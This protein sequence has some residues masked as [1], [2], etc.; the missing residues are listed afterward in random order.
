MNKRSGMLLTTLILFLSVAAI[1]VSLVYGYFFKEIEVDEHDRV[2]GEVLVST[3]IYFQNG[4]TKTPAIL[5]ST[6]NNEVKPNTYFVNISDLTNLYHINKLRVDFTVNSNIETY[7]R[8]KIV[9]SLVIINEKA[10]GEIEEITITRT[11]SIPYVID[12][13]NW[14]YDDLEWFYFKDIVTNE[15]SLINFIQAG[16]SHPVE[17]VQNKIQLVILIEAV[18]AHRGPIENWKLAKRPW[19]GGDWTW[20]KK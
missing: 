7:F 15:S 10:G 13:N 19:D 1:A 9:D 2:V 5:F 8:V 4:A 20:W 14:Y 17:S 6:M 11:E 3:D 18:Q 16:L 12:A